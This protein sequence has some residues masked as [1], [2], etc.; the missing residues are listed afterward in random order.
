MY[1]L[2]NADL[3]TLCNLYNDSR[4]LA[5]YL[6]VIQ[7][8]K[9][10]DLEKSKDNCIVVGT[11]YSSVLWKRFQKKSLLVDWMV[12]VQESFELNHETLYSVVQLV[13][14]YLTDML[15]GKETLQL[16]EV[17]SL[18]IASKF[19]ERI[20]LMVDDFL[21]LCDGAYTQRELLRTKR[22]ILK[23]MDF[24]LRIPLSYRFLRRYA[25]CT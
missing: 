23:I 9:S 7:L 10:L 15:V 20:P 4:V 5:I 2:N 13:D 11:H 25:R 16:L 21:Y 3:R 14:L 1:H 12:A 19:D 22:S 6:S 18:F 24:D 8:R 17:A